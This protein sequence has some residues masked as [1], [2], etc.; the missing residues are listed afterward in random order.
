M[1]LLWSRAGR[2]WAE[3]IPAIVDAVERLPGCGVTIDGEAVC[4]D[5]RGHPDFHAL[6]SERTCREVKLIAFDLPEFDGTNLRRLPLEICR[7]RLAA[8][9]ST[10]CAQTDHGLS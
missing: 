7:R 3:A 6:R 10:S 5:E 1:T 4:L 9:Q 2:N 8:L